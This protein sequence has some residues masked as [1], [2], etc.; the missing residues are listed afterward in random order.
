MTHTEV[1]GR[2]WLGV[3][4]V[5][6]MSA[7]VYLPGLGRNGLR[8][9]EGHRTIP[10]WHIVDTGEWLPTRMFE[11]V[12]VR[13]PPGMP[14]AIALSSMIFGQTEFAARLPSA[15]GS[16]LA[17]L[18][19]FAAA[20]RWFGSLGGAIA[21]GIAQSLAPGLWA[22]GRSAEIETLNNL[23]TALLV[24]GLIDIL[25]AKRA[26]SDAE[27][28]RRHPAAISVL[29]L[30]LFGA[31][32]MKGPA[33][34]PVLAGAIL[35]A[36]LVVGWKPVV[37]SGAMWLGL[38]I[39]MTLSGGLA[40]MVVDAMRAATSVT[41]GAAAT[42]VVTDKLVWWHL[43]R[44]SDLGEVLALAPLTFAGALPGALALLFPFGPDA[45]AEATDTE[46]HFRLGIARALALGFVAS[47]AIYLLVGV[48]NPRYTMP[49]SVFAAPAVAYVWRALRDGMT[50][51]RARI[52]RA[53]MLGHPLVLLGALLLSAAA[54]IIVA[55]PRRGLDSGREA[56]R[57]LSSWLPDGAE[58]WS[59]ELVE[60][61]P[62]TL[63]YARLAAAEQGKR[64]RVIWRPELTA[65]WPPGV[66]LALVRSGGVARGEERSARE[67][68]GAAIVEVGSTRVHVYEVVLLRVERPK[69]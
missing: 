50:P 54:W 46:A 58:V 36:A 26:A 61:R 20:W 3:I 7:L 63:M 2:L 15:L 6:A 11:A 31:A 14:W 35:G 17:S 24:Y 52:A 64:V 10:A 21:A 39:G 38:F 60:S 22:P 1:R 5:A 18:L 9:T 43:W 19:A 65:P 42:G 28:T 68:P 37:R 47:V 49:A 32:L 4:V 56:G 57:E 51:V 66:F 8:S 69:D 45:R 44:E 48:S 23:M 27:S 13:K 67:T 16:I 29:A 62:E 30:G 25:V 53:M 41:P 34:L 12:Y 40:W 33:S 59:H 55:E